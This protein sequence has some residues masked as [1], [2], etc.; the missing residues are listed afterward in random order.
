MKNRKGCLI[1]RGEVWYAAWKVGGK[2]FVKST[3]LR[4]RRD[5]EVELKKMMEP[6]ASGDEVRT[7]QNLAG[8]IEGRKKEIA[9]LEELANPPLSIADAWTAY[10][11]APSRPDSGESTLAQYEAEFNRF[12]RW[13]GKAV[14]GITLLRDVTPQH[15]TAYAQDLS[16]ANVSVS[17]FNQH[18]GFLR[19][20]WRVLQEK[21][22][23]AGNPWEKV[24][25][26]RLVAHSRRELTIEELRRVCH[27]AEGELRLLFAIG[28]Y[29]GLRLG[30]C[31]TLRWC[32]VD[33]KRSMIRRIPMKTARRKGNMVVIPIHAILQTMLEESDK[34]GEYVLPDMFQEYT[35]DDSSLPKKIQAHFLA[36]NIRTHKPGTGFI[37]KTAED[38]SVKQVSTGKRGVVEVGFHSLRHTF[39][40]LC[41]E[42]NAP[43]AVVEA[44]VGHSNP[45]MTRH[46]THVSEAAAGAAVASLPSI[47]SDAVAA[48]PA[49][50]RDPLPAW[51]RQRLAA[52]TGETWQAIRDEVLA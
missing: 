6:F 25:R 20:L 46:Y 48:L 10:L 52:M 15:A 38:G 37:T 36:H 26:K 31:V 3:G 17:T 7:L 21:A 50:T 43:L 42:A 2:Q 12:E 49:A 18:I 14:A 44:I 51:A 33:L 40:S 29:T 24:Q 35:H 5:A 32:E 13:A 30:D 45:A 28:I 27:G 47:L 41:R 11:E 16:K 4:D 34:R 8:V 23:L 39:V 22:R 1:K 9:N 19:L